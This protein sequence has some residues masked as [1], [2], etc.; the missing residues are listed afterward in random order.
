MPWHKIQWFFV[1]IIVFHVITSICK[2]IDCVMHCLLFLPLPLAAYLHLLTILILLMSFFKHTC[3]ANPAEEWKWARSSS[4]T[5][6]HLLGKLSNA[7]SSN[8]TSLCTYRSWCSPIFFLSKTSHAL[9]A[10]LESVFIMSSTKKL[11]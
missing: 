11:L 3:Y 8:N 10:C 5:S 7:S 2:L 4:Y 9:F 1:F 6:I